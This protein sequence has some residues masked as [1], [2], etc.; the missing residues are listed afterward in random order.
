[1][2]KS[3]YAKLILIFIGVF[4]L[5]NTFAFMIVSWF[6]EKDFMNDVKNQISQFVADTKQIYESGRVSAE[7]IEKLQNSGFMK[8]KFLNSTGEIGSCGR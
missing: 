6:Q 1:M 3:I 5:G 2:R 7:D 4:L 8:V